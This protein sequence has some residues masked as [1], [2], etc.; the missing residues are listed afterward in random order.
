MDDRVP[1]DDSFSPEFDS[2]A[3]EYSDLIDE[4]VKA[5]GQGIPRPISRNTKLKRLLIV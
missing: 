1:E 5:S 2:F 4:N 3:H